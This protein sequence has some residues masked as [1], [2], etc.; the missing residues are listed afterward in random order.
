METTKTNTTRLE[1]IRSLQPTSSIFVKLTLYSL[2]SCAI[3]ANAWGQWKS[4]P[5]A[6][7]SRV[8][9]TQVTGVPQPDGHGGFTFPRNPPVIDGTIAGD[10][11]WTSSFRY[12]FS[13]G[14]DSPDAAVQ[15]IKD[16]DFI[17]LSFEVNNDLSYDDNDV[18]VLTFSPN[19]TAA[20]DQRLEI[21][22]NNTNIQKPVGS[23]PRDVGYWTNSAAWDLGGARSAIPAQ[24]LIKV[25]NS[26]APNSSNV[27]WF[28]EMKLPIVGFNIPA[29]G[30]FGFYFNVIAG[31]RSNETAPEYFWPPITGGQISGLLDNNTPGQANWGNGTRDPGKS[32]LGVSFDWS[33]I[34]SNH[35]QDQIDAASMPN[36][37]Q[38]TAVLHNNSVDPTGVP[39][40]ASQVTAKFSI[41]DF[42]LA[43][44]TCGSWTQIPVTKNPTDPH[45]ILAGS[46]FPFTSS[47][48]WNITDPNQINAYK[49]IPDQCIL[50]DLDSK[51]LNTFFVNKSARRNMTVQTAS[52]VSRTP[53]INANGFDDN[54]KADQE[55]DLHV[56]SHQEVVKPGDNLPGHNIPSSTAV[57]TGGGNRNQVYTHLTWIAHGCRR[58]GKFVTIGNDKWEICEPTGAFGYSLLHAG[59]QAVDHWDVSLD[60]GKNV[61]K[62]G[63]DYHVKVA[64]NQ[65]LKLNQRLV[66]VETKKGCSVPGFG[67]A[68][69]LFFGF[70]V[71]GLTVYRRPRTGND[72]GLDR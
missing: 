19:G 16:N 52:E 37:N 65:K 56:V 1:W 33:D 25:S 32:C 55:F 59:A 2:L 20:N 50:V 8:C 66:P 22:P 54:G 38:F 68:G 40:T 18:I 15:G 17:Y 48:G 58:T 39:V 72:N 42:G 49:A 27:S 63:N 7:N 10:T 67:G 5:A 30:D 11:G 71:V 29:T 62:V 36:N 23:D 53:V 4:S 26:G 31:T 60:G 9:F 24:T 57:T 43:C 46:S 35:N 45:D 14:T 21:F 34:T 69:F 44:A 28:V 3:T 12:V 47:P 51:A 13:N 70:L 64:K 6:A 61:T 41:A